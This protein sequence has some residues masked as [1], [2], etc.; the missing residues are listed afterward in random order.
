MQIRCF[1]VVEILSSMS[2]RDV[3]SDFVSRSACDEEVADEL[4]IALL[5][6]TLG[7]IRRHGA[8]CC[9]ELNPQIPIRADYRLTT[10]DCR[11]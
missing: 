7:D 8:R 6:E 3:R 9:G 11:L 10:T 1:L 4:P 5:T 2:D